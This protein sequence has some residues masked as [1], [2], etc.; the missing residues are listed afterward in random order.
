MF[1]LRI[2]E[3]IFEL[4]L[5]LLCKQMAIKKNEVIFLVLGLALFVIHSI[6]FFFSI[7]GLV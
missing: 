6:V 3:N 1:V 7:S 2:N 4:I 5:G